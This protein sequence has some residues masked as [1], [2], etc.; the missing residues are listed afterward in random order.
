MSI[1]LNNYTHLIL[2][3]ISEEEIKK[4]KDVRRKIKFL[5][6]YLGSTYLK[7]YQN[8]KSNPFQFRIKKEIRN[9]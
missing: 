7:K 8:S 3:S 1:A 9:D 5:K 2:G 4:N 6:K